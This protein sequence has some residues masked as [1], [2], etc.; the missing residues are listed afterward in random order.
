MTGIPLTVT[1]AA[2]GPRKTGVAAPAAPIDLRTGYRREPSAW[3]HD[4]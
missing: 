4:I 2:A 3:T 1:D